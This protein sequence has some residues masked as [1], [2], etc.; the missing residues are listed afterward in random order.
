[1]L[2]GEVQERGTDL[3]TVLDPEARERLKKLERRD[4][5]MT[6]DAFQKRVRLIF[7]SFQAAWA[8]RDLKK[9]RPFFTD[10]L[11]DTQRYWVEAYRAQGLRNVTENARVEH[12]ELAR[13]VSDRWFDAITIRLRASSLDYTLRDSDGELVSGSSSNERRYTEYWTL[14]RGASRKS[15]PRATPECPNCGAPLDVEMAGDCRYCRAKITTGEF[16]WVLS[17]IEQDEVYRG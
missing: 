17:R 15:A 16:D 5:T 8:E 13:V 2:T 11:F 3:E 12:V 9:M 4:P 7:G 10:A 6:W 14:I 1:M